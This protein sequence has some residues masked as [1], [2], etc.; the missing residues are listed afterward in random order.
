MTSCAGRKLSYA[1]TAGLQ[2][3]VTHM[4]HDGSD[5]PAG[6][7]CLDS[8]RVAF[9]EPRLV[10][11]AGLLLTATLAHRLGLDEL[12]NES[13]WLGYRVRRCRAAR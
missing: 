1:A 4:V 5:V 10:S 6:P 3:E 2:Q 7:A 12:V 8:V 13:V 11:D 9:D